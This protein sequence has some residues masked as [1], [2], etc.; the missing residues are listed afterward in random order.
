MLYKTTCT[1]TGNFYIGVHSTNLL[2]DEYLGSGMRL[3]YSIRKYGKENHCREVLELF[4]SRESMMQ[5]EREVVNENLLRDEKCMNLKPGGDGGFR[6]EEHRKNFQLAG[7]RAGNIAKSKL[8]NDPAW[9]EKNKLAISKGLKK[10]KKKMYPNRA[11]S[12]SHRDSI[13]KSNSASQAGKRNS[14][15]G[16]K[17]MHKGT[18][19]IKVK[20]DDL[21]TMKMQGWALGRQIRD[22]A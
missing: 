2:E 21:E 7:S 1:V 13:G 20:P 17:W 8:R 4:D 3:R 14:Q 15:F 12:K 6:N 5:K 11:L 16:T 18:M 19:N 9:N 22:I 10:G